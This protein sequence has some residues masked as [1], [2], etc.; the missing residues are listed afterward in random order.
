MPS[1]GK[2]KPYLEQVKLKRIILEKGWLLVIPLLFVSIVTH[3]QPIRFSEFYDADDGA[4]AILNIVESDNGFIA[5]GTNFKNGVRQSH[6]IEIDSEGQLLTDHTVFDV[7][8]GYESFAMVRLS[9]GQIAS[10]GSLCDYNV[11]SPGYCDFYFAL[12]DESGDTVF[13]N[14]YPRI[15]TTDILLS[16]IET[17]PNK[18]MLIGWTYDDTTNTDSD[19]LFITVDTLG[20]ELNRVVYGGGGADYI[21]SGIV[22]NEE[23]SVLMTGYTSSFQGADNDS[24]LILTD[25]IGNVSWQKTY[26]HLSPSGGDAGSRVLESI[27]GGL[28][29]V[30]GSHNSLTGNSDGYLMKIDSTG[31]P[32]WTKKYIPT[33]GSQSFWSGSALSDGSVLACGQTT[34]TSNGSQAGWLV[35]ADMNGDTIWTRTYNPSD[36]IDL[37]RNML[38]MDNGDIVMVGFGEGDNSTTQDGWILRVDSMGCV[39]ENCTGSVGADDDLST[40]HS[41]KLSIYPNPAIN[42][43]NISLNGIDAKESEVVIHDL[44]GKE[45]HRFVS[46]SDRE[47]IDVSTWARGIYHCS[48][49]SNQRLL[50]T[51]KLILMR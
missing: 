46:V 34:N 6:T 11:P 47:I 17:R 5:Q 36:D 23:G 27:N 8:V 13:T 39:V 43:L 30:G 49:Y 44:M 31:D 45:I 40:L 15:D 24:W 12:L 4:G 42:Q 41:E 22:I 26:N 51:E 19:L 18:I 38:V 3:A 20:N 28:F 7:Q 21:H 32:V 35:K 1:N 16:M 33:S 29:I 2:W 37:L 48:L 50:Q 10:A 25:S 14:V 9:T